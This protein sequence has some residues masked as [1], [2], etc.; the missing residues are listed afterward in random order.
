MGCVSIHLVLM[1]R[2]R[3]MLITVIYTDL[4]A[5]SKYVYI[6]IDIIRYHV[7]RFEQDNCEIQYEGIGPFG[8]SNADYFI[9]FYI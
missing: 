2:V 8:V 4:Y 9:N 5:L 3:I 6:L 7:L 1:F